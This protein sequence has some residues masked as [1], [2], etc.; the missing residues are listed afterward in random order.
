MII[1]IDKNSDRKIRHA[2]VRKK[3]EG[4][5]QKPR[6]CVYKSLSHIYVQFIDDAKG[7][8]LVSCST[9]E[10]EI[11]EKVKGLKK[12]AAAKSVGIEAAK[13]AKAKGI[14]EVV[15]DRGGYLY[16]GRVK[17]VADGAREGGLKF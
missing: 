9:M 7:V 14:S 2:R 1:K 16:T 8:T 11:K 4:S 12:S 3:I 10:N 13:R 17:S 5:E 15:F 6:L